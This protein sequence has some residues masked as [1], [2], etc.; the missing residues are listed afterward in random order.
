MALAS[1]GHARTIYECT[2]ED[3]GPN[4]GWLPTVVYVAYD[5]DAEEVQV[6]DPMIQDING[7]PLSVKPKTDNDV[8]LSLSWKLM[9]ESTSQNEYEW[10]YEFTVYKADNKAKITGIPRGYSDT[11][12][13]PGTCRVKKG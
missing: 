11:L 5:P 8:R 9:L 12:Y 1:A 4:R 2:F 7:G 3:R 13:A 10:T 6:S